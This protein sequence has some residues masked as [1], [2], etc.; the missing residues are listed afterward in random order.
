M[1]LQNWSRHY[2]DLY[3]VTVA[4]QKA[5]LYYRKYL[6]DLSLNF[7]ADIRDILGPE[8]DKKYLCLIFRYS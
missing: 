2:G 1:K 8:N 7:E 5:L 4:G 3:V 6:E